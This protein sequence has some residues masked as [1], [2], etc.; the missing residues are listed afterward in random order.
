MTSP[1]LLVS[2][3]QRPKEGAADLEQHLTASLVSLAGTMASAACL[4]KCAGL[5]TPRAVCTAGPKEGVADLA[6]H[7]RR[8]AMASLRD[9]GAILLWSHVYSERWSAFAPGFRELRDNEARPRGLVLRP[10]RRPPG[11][12]SA[13]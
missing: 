11:E 12:S 4:V 3:P 13:E 6:W 8:S 1:F 5:T 7:P 10:G 9:S 2:C